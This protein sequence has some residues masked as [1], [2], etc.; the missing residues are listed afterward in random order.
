MKNSVITAL[1]LAL[2]IGQV[3][4]VSSDTKLRILKY[5]IEV[6]SDD[7]AKMIIK[8]IDL[9]EIKTSILNDAKKFGRTEIVKMLTRR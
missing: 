3:F 8:G 2:S 4:S 5:A 6:G 9:R 1:V 7:V